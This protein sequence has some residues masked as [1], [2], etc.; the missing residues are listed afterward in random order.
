MNL[1]TSVMNPNPQHLDDV[2][3]LVILHCSLS[4]EIK[5][6]QNWIA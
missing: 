3:I 4:N 6:D 1:M 5:N 2:V